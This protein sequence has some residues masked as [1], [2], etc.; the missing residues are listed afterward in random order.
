VATGTAN[1][2]D[3][4]AP[5]RVL[6]GLEAYLSRHHLNSPAELTGAVCD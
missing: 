4:S 3:P 6:E 1:F 5:L 2:T